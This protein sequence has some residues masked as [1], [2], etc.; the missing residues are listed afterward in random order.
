MRIR[1]NLSDKVLTAQI[2]WRITRSDYAYLHNTIGMEVFHMV[3]HTAV[4]LLMCII[5]IFKEHC[6]TLYV[7]AL[8]SFI[9]SSLSRSTTWISSANGILWQTERQRMTISIIAKIWFTL[10][11]IL[12]ICWVCSAFSCSP[13]LLIIMSTRKVMM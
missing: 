3:I 13:S 12:I 7:C 9:F 5:A 6:Y 11:V 2:R 10:S 4:P 8:F 1:W